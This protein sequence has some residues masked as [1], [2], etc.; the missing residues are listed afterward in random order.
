M[1]EN[2]QK[3]I[4]NN[5]HITT[6]NEYLSELRTIHPAKVPGIAGGTKYIFEDL[7]LFVKFV[8]DS[9]VVDCG[10]AVKM[11]CD[12]KILIIIKALIFFVCRLDTN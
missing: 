11:V 1:K 4:H 8:V 2:Y 10:M 3:V 9:D 12:N 6:I 7:N 5:H